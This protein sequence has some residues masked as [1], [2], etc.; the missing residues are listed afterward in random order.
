MTDDKQK[1]IINLLYIFLIISTLCA[2]VP[3]IMAQIAFISLLFVTLISAYYY[4]TKDRPDGL[5][6]NHMTY[7]IGTVWIGSFLLAVGMAVAGYWVFMNGNNQPLDDFMRSAQSGVIPDEAA[8]NEAM[9]AYMRINMQ[10]ILVST[11]L[12]VGP[13][14]IYLVYRIA[15]GYSRAMKGYRIAKPKSWL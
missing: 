13:A 4:K 8:M 12:F 9:I 15:H 6:H 7:L 5:L 1:S 11:I 14:V 2:F 3:F 10:L